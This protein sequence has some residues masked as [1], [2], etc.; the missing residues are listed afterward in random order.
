M[1]LSHIQVKKRVPSTNKGKLFAYVKA[2]TLE[3]KLFREVLPTILVSLVGLMIAGE[4]LDI[5][6]NYE[7]FET[8]SELF[9]LVPILLGLK[10]DLEMT[11]AARLSTSANL[12]LLDSR[13][14]LS[15]SMIVCFL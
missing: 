7:M 2:H 3:N 10:G 8:H 13:D 12:G 9:I 14:S 6:Q 5:I 4:T 15:L 11:L 1:K